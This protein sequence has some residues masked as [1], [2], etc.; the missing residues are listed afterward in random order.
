M[1]RFLIAMTS[2][3]AAFKTF[4]SGYDYTGTFPNIEPRLLASGTTSVGLKMSAFA[5]G[6]AY[7]ADM[8]SD[9]KPSS[10]SAANAY[11]LF[12][13]GAIPSADRL[14]ADSNTLPEPNMT[15][16]SNVI[17]KATP[18]EPATKALTK[19]P[20]LWNRASGSWKP[21]SLRTSSR[22]GPSGDTDIPGDG[23]T[24]NGSDGAGGYLYCAYTP[25]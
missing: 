14:Y 21:S 9:L 2:G 3:K 1:K 22:L 15:F 19:Y 10:T 20:T 16:A 11:A 24:G 7:T 6:T 18:D 8:N 17:K 13:N 25:N 4:L 12:W 5:I 23:N